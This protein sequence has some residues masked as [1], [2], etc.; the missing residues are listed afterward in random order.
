[1]FVIIERMEYK[2]M[3]KRF[4][5]IYIFILT[6]ILTS[7]GGADKE[8]TIK[9]EG[10]VQESEETAEEEKPERDK[11]GSDKDSS[12]SSEH[13][14]YQVGDVIFYT[15]GLNVTIIDSGLYSKANDFDD[16]VVD[17]YAFLE[18]DIENNGSED[19]AITGSIF[20]FYADGYALKNVYL[21]EDGELPLACDLSPGRKV[22]GRVYATGENINTS[23]H[24]EAELGDTVIRIYENSDDVLG[25][26]KEESTV[27]PD[28]CGTYVS[29]D[30]YVYV[31]IA[32]INDTVAE[33]SFG[34]LELDEIE[35]VLY[36][37][38]EKNE[39]GYYL[40]ASDDEQTVN[41][42]KTYFE[43]YESDGLDIGGCEYRSYN[44]L[45]VREDAL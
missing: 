45:Y 33:I 7:C 37:S 28:F 17:H 30:G 18:V 16:T 35:F 40:S 12:N 15:S 23:K 34:R 39:N 31:E 6:G 11:T 21:Y 14:E 29:I 3:K 41:V 24:I 26:I 8:Q 5:F 38:I 9:D 32:N 19:I 25:K 36:A 20:E 42:Y 13:K 27:I 4:L 22:K 2:N 43:E 44:N 1:M 10:I